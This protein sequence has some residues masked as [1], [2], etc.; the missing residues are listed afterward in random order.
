[1]VTY[2]WALWSSRNDIRQGGKRKTGLELVRGAT[3]YLEEF[4]AANTVEEVGR[5]LNTQQVL[6]VPPQ[7]QT[8]KANVDGAVFAEI[9]AVGIGVVIRDMEGKVKAALCQKIKAPFG[10][11][12]AEAKAFEM[13]TQFAKD[14]GIRDVVIEG[15]SLIVQRALNELAPPPP[16]VDAVV[17]GILDAAVDFQHI[18][19]THVGRKGNKPAH[20]LAKYAKSI[21]NVLVWIEEIPC[22]IEQALI[23]DVMSF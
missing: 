21:D 3:Q 16:S 5:N 6:W 1:M 22:V 14:L 2:A 9:K 18:A 15:D 20:L 12:E 23:Q 7:G 8:F 10:P 19:F 4:H 11:V 13:G 17:M